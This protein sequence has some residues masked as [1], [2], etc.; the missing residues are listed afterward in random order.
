MLTLFNGSLSYSDIMNMTLKDLD[1]LR[2]ARLKA[3]MQEQE[4]MKRR[5][6]ERKREAARN[7]III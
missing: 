5:E 3:L 1:E 4:E 6:D 2:S 7:Q